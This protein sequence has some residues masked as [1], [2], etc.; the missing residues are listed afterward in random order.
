MDAK[1][2]THN[3]GEQ[4]WVFDIKRVDYVVKESGRYMCIT[5]LFDEY[6]EIPLKIYD[7]M[8]LVR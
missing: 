6:E 1:I 7:C 3:T 8:I 2:I 5:T 4:R